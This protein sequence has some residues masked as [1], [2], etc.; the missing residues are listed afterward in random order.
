[1]RHDA[2]LRLIFLFLLFLA[3]EAVEQIVDPLVI[4]GQMHI[5]TPLAVMFEWQFV[6]ISY[7]EVDLIF[8]NQFGNTVNDNKKKIVI[9][10]KLK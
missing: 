10:M 2:I 5:L 1:M 9:K 8:I 7:G 3:G 6:V 4:L